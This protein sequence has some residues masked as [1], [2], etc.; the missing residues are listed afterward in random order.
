MANKLSMR[1][2]QSR[3]E[4]YIIVPFISPMYCMVK[5]V[6]VKLL[7][8]NIKEYIKIRIILIK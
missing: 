1:I 5:N 4:W 7:L 2:L 8:I 3:W 6:T